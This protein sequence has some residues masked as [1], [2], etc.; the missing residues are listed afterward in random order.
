MPVSP[1]A[2]VPT[3]SI[4]Q[5]PFAKVPFSNPEQKTEPKIKGYENMKTMLNLP[6]LAA[7]EVQQNEFKKALALVPGNTSRVK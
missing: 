1:A 2:S 3:P 6:A 4:C 7:L 5:S